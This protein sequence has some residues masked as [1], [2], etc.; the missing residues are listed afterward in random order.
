LLATYTK[1]PGV[2]QRFPFWNSTAIDLDK[3]VEHR[4]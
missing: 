4:K 2:Y 3:S 1:L